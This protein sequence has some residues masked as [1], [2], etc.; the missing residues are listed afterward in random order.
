MSRLPAMRRAM[1]RI[2]TRPERCA[3]CGRPL[4]SGRV[5]KD[6]KAGGVLERYH[7]SCAPSLGRRVV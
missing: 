2:T 5:V 3:G 7:Q 6:V 1:R 4:T